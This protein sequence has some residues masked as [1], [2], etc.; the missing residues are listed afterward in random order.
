MSNLIISEQQ[1][2][3][4]NMTFPTAQYQSTPHMRKIS[5]KTNNNNL[6]FKCIV[7]SPIKM[8]QRVRNSAINSIGG[9]E[10]GNKPIVTQSSDQQV[11]FDCRTNTLIEADSPYDCH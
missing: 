2:D 5:I 8:K 6:P 7:N 1:S 3:K 11:V 9:F 4:E 10:D